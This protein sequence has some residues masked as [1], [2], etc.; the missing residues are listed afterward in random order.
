MGRY[1]PVSGCGSFRLS[2]RGKRIYCDKPLHHLGKCVD[3]YGCRWKLKLQGNRFKAGT[4]Q[5]PQ[6]RGA[7]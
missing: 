7:R 2:K 1:I 3:R 4:V 5:L 6:E